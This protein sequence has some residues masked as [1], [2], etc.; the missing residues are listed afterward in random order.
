M[1]VDCSHGS[2]SSYYGPDPTQVIEHA[3]T[4]WILN[5]SSSAE[6]RIYTVDHKLLWRSID[7]KGDWPGAIWADKVRPSTN[8]PLCKCGS[9]Q[10]PKYKNF[11]NCPTTKCGVEFAPVVSIDL[12][13]ESKQEATDAEQNDRAQMMKNAREAAANQTKR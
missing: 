3:L 4:D 9:F 13:L 10:R 12:K 7:T 1:T 6:A 8:S 2:C 11:R 5:S